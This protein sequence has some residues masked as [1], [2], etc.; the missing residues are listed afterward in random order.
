M[1]MQTEIEE[2]KIKTSAFFKHPKDPGKD[3]LSQLL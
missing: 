3:T 2:G 1:D